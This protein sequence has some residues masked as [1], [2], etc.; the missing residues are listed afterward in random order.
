MRDAKSQQAMR[1][2]AHTEEDPNDSNSVPAQ[3]ATRPRRELIDHIP[4]ILEI[5]VETRHGVEVTVNVLPS[6][7]EQSPLQIELTNENLDLLLEHPAAASAPFI[8]T[9][10]HTDVSWVSN[11]NQV[12]CRYWASK[13]KQWTI[14][15]KL[16]EFDSDMDDDQKQL[17]VDREA[18][19]M[20]QFFDDS[21]NLGNDMPCP[22]DSA[23]SAIEEP[24]EKKARIE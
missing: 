24:P 11:R 7:R 20:Q 16:L 12:R 14:K 4:R 17:Q 6:W 1:G 8:A 22:D 5:S 9:I 10:S 18:L 21:H 23:E 15:S 3:A 2:L 19:V 13:K